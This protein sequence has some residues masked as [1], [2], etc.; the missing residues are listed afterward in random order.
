MKL[1]TALELL[2]PRTH[3]VIR[4]SSP[5][6]N[7]MVKF[8]CERCAEATFASDTSRRS[9][10]AFSNT[11]PLAN[12]LIANHNTALELL[13][14]QTPFVIRGSIPQHISLGKVTTASATLYYNYF[15]LRH[16]SCPEVAFPN[17][18]Q[19][20]NWRVSTICSGITAL[21]NA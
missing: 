14:P 8:D 2:L 6:H 1:N 11:F 7:H 18:C 15:C 5:Q 17:T 10:V 3:Y 12:V 4:G 9:E 16:I 20:A 19:L 21:P 13:L